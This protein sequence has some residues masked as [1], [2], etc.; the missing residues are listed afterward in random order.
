V[1]TFVRGALIAGR[2]RLERPLAKGGMGSVWIARHVEL[3]VDVA[4]KLVSEELKSE[5]TTHRRLR[6]E[7]KAAAKLKSPHITQIHDSG[8]HEGAPYIVMELLE[9]DCLDEL[10]F[11]EGKLPVERAQQLFAELCAG[12]S[13][14]HEAGI[15]HRD[16]KPSNIFVARVAGKDVVKILDFGI[17]KDTRTQVPDHDPTASGTLLGSPRYMSPE[18]AT[19]ERVDFRS[20][21]WSAAVVLFEVI[22]GRR[23]F[24]ADNLG[25]IIADI[26][27]GELPAPSAVNTDLD[28][29]IDAF[30]AVALERVPQRRFESATEMARAFDSAARGEPLPPPADP[31]RKTEAP[32]ENTGRGRIE[33]TEEVSTDSR[34]RVTVPDR[35]AGSD[36][37]IAAT[38]DDD[39][40]ADAPLGTMRKSRVPTVP[41]RARALE[42]ARAAPAERTA[43]GVGLER[44]EPRTRKPWVLLMA[45]AGAAAIAI[46]IGVIGNGGADMSA[47]PAAQGASL[48]AS[49]IATSAPPRTGGGTGG[50]TASPPA[51][52]EASVTAAA[53]PDAPRRTELRAPTR[54]SAPSAS[55]LPPPPPASPPAVPPPPP[56]APRQE[57]TTNEFGLKVCRPVP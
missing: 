40:T 49:G 15:V 54:T 14:A 51:T 53:S 11:R 45:A 36:P 35:V 24:A 55:V 42:S 21:L 30:F 31:A 18:Q 27:A 2:Y 47:Q 32:L 9:G 37:A 48:T 41:D 6:R 26:C 7:A 50:G 13:V 57:C 1:S 44:S 22:T 16:L 52:A 20:D 10:L 33:P 3:D 34:A 29:H 5:E 23:L 12:L 19:G 56:A 39:A 17:A 46:G 43:P 8:V 4:V 28:E 38:R 25:R